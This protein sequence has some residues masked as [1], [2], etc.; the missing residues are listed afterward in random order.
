[1]NHGLGLNCG[2]L[3]RLWLHPPHWSEQRWPK[4]RQKLLQHWQCHHQGVSK[5]VSISTQQW[6]DLHEPFPES[7]ANKEG[8]WSMCSS[9]GG[10]Q[11]GK[12]ATHNF[13]NM[14][15]EIQHIIYGVCFS[16]LWA[17]QLIICS[18]SFSP[19]TVKLTQFGYL[20]FLPLLH[21]KYSGVPL[22]ALH[23]NS[24]YIFQNISKCHRRML[25]K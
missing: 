8:C 1:M 14:Q 22:P 11:G 19:T 15:S 3:D 20:S 4:G 17:Q 9:N 2:Y 5:H 21:L 16:L 13:N 24:N 23:S 25:C 6:S 12:V 7:C 10:H 18:T